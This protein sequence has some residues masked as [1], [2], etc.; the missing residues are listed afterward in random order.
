MSPRPE[1]ATT[2]AN[3]PATSAPRRR[4]R[5]VALCARARETLLRMRA[6]VR[7][8]AHSGTGRGRRRH[9]PR[10]APRRAHAGTCG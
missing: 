9:A 8:A 2:L 10:R 4:W 7:G 3:P 5:R 6:F 1:R